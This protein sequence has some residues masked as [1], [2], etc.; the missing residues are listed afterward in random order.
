MPRR[1]FALRWRSATVT[2]CGP[3]G[4]AGHLGN[5]VA[6]LRAAEDSAGAVPLQLRKVGSHE[7]QLGP[8]HSETLQATVLLANCMIRAGA[9]AVALPL[10][11]R[12][13]DVTERLLGL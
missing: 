11:L 7:R 1:C 9:A 5:L 12:V 3:S 6:C 2:P 10:Y 4:H 13:L 8:R